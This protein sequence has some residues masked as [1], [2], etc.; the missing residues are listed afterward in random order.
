[1]Q[2]SWKFDNRDVV[3]VTDAPSYGMAF[4]AASDFVQAAG[5]EYTIP[6]SLADGEDNDE[7]KYEFRVK[8][9]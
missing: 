4:D 2:V 5:D 3:V 9:Y 8:A 6:L 1:M 7:D